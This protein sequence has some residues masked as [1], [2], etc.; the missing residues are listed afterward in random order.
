MEFNNNK[1]CSKC[2]KE[3]SFSG[4]YNKSSAKDGKNSQ[5]RDCR[6]DYVRNNR[7][8]IL[9]TRRKYNSK[10]TTRRKT[11]ARNHGMTIEEYDNFF[12]V[13]NYQCEV[14]GMTQKESYRLFNVDLCIDHCHTTGENK[15]LLCNVC[16][17]AGGMLK[18][19]PDL[20]FRLWRYL[21][22]TR[23]KEN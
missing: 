21:E 1:V 11:N 14:C 18:D 23:R 13:R 5:C 8:S 17:P 12:A 9:A 15:G 10:D 4:F 2:K 16:N 7:E 22:R 3:K 6:L 20:A 19:D